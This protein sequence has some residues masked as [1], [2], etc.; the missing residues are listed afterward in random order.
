MSNTAERGPNSNHNEYAV[1]ELKCHHTRRLEK[2]THSLFVFLTSRHIIFVQFI[3]LILRMTQH[4]SHAVFQYGCL[5]KAL[6]LSSFPSW[7]SY[8]FP[9][10]NCVTSHC[11]KCSQGQDKRHTFLCCVLRRRE[12]CIS[13]SEE[14]AG[15]SDENDPKRRA[16]KQ[17]H[18]AYSLCF[19]EENISC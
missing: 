7:S 5:S 18:T 15:I 11:N 8:Y 6:F 16:R 4:V 2:Y 17:V 13:G 14:N 19:R 10:Y 12:N 1:T 9:V 3:M